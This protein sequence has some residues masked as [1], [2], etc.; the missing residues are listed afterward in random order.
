MSMSK[1]LKTA[2]VAGLLSS[3]LF[4]L[5]FGVGLGFV[6][7]FLPTLPLFYAGLGVHARAARDGSLIA[8]LIV[9]LLSG[10][11]ALV[12]YFLFLG[13]PA[14]YICNRA[15]MARFDGLEAQWYPVGSIMTRLA[16]WGCG[17]VALITV[18]YW[19][20]D[21]GLPAMLADT[22]REAFTGLHDEYGDVIESLANNWAFLIFPVTLWLWCIMMYVHAWVVNRWL[23]KKGIMR[24]PDFAITPFPIPSWLLSLLAICALASLIGS[25]SMR[26]LGKASLV[27]LMLPYFFL[28]ATILRDST[29]HWPNHRFFLFFIYFVVFTQFWPALI[30]SG[31]GLWCQIKHLSGSD[32][33]IRK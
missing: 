10:P 18:Y 21:G 32:S 13:L 23:V 25:D 7:M 9:C 2:F 24:R 19:H 3:G 30:V 17:L 33:S 12:V 5:V 8:A 27:S 4:V 26:F 1:E 11:S 22:I 16:F 14:S 6:F 15:M 20:Q 29:A 31:I 28:G